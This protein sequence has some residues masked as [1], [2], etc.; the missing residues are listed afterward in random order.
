MVVGSRRALAM[1]VRNGRPGERNATLGSGFRGRRREAG[2]R[3]LKAV[4]ATRP[5]VGL[6]S[7]R[8]V[9]LTCTFAGVE[10]S[11]P[12]APHATGVA[13]GT[14]RSP[15]SASRADAVF[16]HAAHSADSAQGG[17]CVFQ[18]HLFNVP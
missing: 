3:F 10:V 12:G 18:G 5:P 8:P 4:G 9:T 7:S 13:G 11:L 14:P 15:G 16:A 2:R 17:T 1:A 6:Q